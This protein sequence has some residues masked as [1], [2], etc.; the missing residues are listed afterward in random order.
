MFLNAE[1]FFESF[2]Q[3]RDVFI[4]GRKGSGK[5]L[6]S[7]AMARYALDNKFVAGVFANIPHAMPKA[8]SVANAFVIVDESWQFIDNRFSR[9]TYSF[10]GAWSR[11][12]NSLWAF[13]SVYGV[14]LRVRNLQCERIADIN[15]LPIRAW[16]YRWTNCW[17]DKGHFVLVRP[18]EYYGS[19]DTKA[20][21]VDDGGAVD[22]LMSLVPDGAKLV[23]RGGGSRASRGT[24]GFESLPAVATLGDLRALQDR[25]AE[26]ERI[27]E[28]LREFVGGPE[29][30]GERIAEGCTGVTPGV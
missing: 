20:I 30:I 7:F 9:G 18:E 17:G 3:I 26:L 24:N 27:V 10:M 25:V 29:H 2:T 19:Y 4:T 15:L 28:Q 14:D 12:T 13:P 11:K 5:T 8:A 23:Q 21:P 16:L 22:S 1:A 6:L